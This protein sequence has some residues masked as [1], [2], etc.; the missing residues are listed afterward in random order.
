MVCSVLLSIQRSWLLSCSPFL[1]GWRCKRSWT[2]PSIWKLRI[3]CLRR[4]CVLWLFSGGSGTPFASENT[5]V[6]IPHADLLGTTNLGTTK[7][8]KHVLHGYFILYINFF[9]APSKHKRNFS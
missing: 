9:N 7:L 8:P 5:V 3:T 1:M 6:S 4:C 2:P